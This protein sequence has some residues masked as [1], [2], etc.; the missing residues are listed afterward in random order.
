M[1][2]KDG[3]IIDYSFKDSQNCDLRD[4]IIENGS[5]NSKIGAV[6]LIVSVIT[7]IICF[8]VILV[9]CSLKITEKQMNKEVEN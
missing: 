2:Y 7:S 6:Y 9:V 4:Y 8:M 1:H 5:N 3:E